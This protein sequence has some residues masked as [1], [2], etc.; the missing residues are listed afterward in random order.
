MNKHSVNKSKHQ[1]KSIEKQDTARHVNYLDMAENDYQ[2][3][4][5]LQRSG[6]QY[7]VIG[8]LAEQTSEKM[9]RHL[10]CLAEN[11]KYADRFNTPNIPN[12]KVHSLDYWATRAMQDGMISCDNH[13]LDSLKKLSRFYTATRYPGQTD[14]RHIEASEIAFCVAIAS[15]VRLMG[16]KA[17]KEFEATSNE[18][19]EANIVIRSQAISNIDRVDNLRT[20]SE[21]LDPYEYERD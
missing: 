6:Q 17:I 21:G 2:A 4:L 20:T 11:I 3:L 9:L 18:Y 14:S 8:A 13:F 12:G 16:A 7:D 5:F 10:V 1:V 19:N 15:M